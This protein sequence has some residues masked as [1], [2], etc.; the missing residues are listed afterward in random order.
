[1]N[2]NSVSDAHIFIERET[3]G[4]EAGVAQKE[5]DERTTLVFSE[6]VLLLEHQLYL[7]TQ[8][9]FCTYLTVIKD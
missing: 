6:I 2:R 1:M 8:F 3:S 4:Y 5:P 9:D 7:N